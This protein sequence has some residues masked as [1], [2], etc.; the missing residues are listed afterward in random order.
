MS[1]SIDRWRGMLGAAAAIG[2]S[3][4]AAPDRPGLPPAAQPPPDWSTAASKGD[5]I[6]WASDFRDPELTAF[7]R[8][9]LEQNPDLVA[10]AARLRQAQAR[11]MIEGA[12]RFPLIEADANVSRRQSAGESRLGAFRPGRRDDFDVGFAAGSSKP[13]ARSNSHSRRVR[14]LAMPSPPSSESSSAASRATP[15][16][17]MSRSAART[18]PPARPTSKP[19]S[20]SATQPCAP[21]RH[22]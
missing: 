5:P 18:S 9:A 21:L 19:G 12:A 17:W 13:G 15:R 2:L 14:R 3:M 4:C 20:A 8:R 11:T 10:V 16:V 22:C 7:V 6:S 1:G